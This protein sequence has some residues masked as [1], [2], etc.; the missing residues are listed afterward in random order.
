MSRHV[1]FSN[2]LKPW[3]TAEQ[4]L[5]QI[6]S[7]VQQ[8]YSDSEEEVEDVSEKENG[9]EYNPEHDTWSSEEQQEE[10]IPQ[11]ERESLLS[12]KKEK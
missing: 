9:E 10:E 12:K 3:L 7:N 4:V 5:E 2:V 8:D 11:V 6:C 1:D